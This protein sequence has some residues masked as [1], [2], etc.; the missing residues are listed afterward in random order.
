MP[1][2]DK[3]K[4]CTCWKLF[5]HKGWV[6]AFL[7]NPATSRRRCPCTSRCVQFSGQGRKF[8]V[9]VERHDV[10]HTDEGVVDIDYREQ[11]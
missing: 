3:C 9:Y 7:I 11:T 8:L 4:L 2:T 6:G 10:K 5:E 1:G